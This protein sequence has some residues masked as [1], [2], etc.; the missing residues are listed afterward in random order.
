MRSRSHWVLSGRFP[1]S[2]NGE[3]A[4]HQNDMSMICS[5]WEK[6]DTR[7]LPPALER[8]Q[9]CPNGIMSA[10]GKWPG[11]VKSCHGYM[12]SNW[13]S[14][15]LHLSQKSVEMRHMLTWVDT[16]SASRGAGGPAEIE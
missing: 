4:R 14:R 6:R 5:S 11:P 12:R 2:I 9:M 15:L 10:S 13:W 7:S 16:C 1:P 8:M 3:G